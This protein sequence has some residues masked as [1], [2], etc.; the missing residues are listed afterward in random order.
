MEY[1]I[2]DK[3]DH[4]CGGGW[5]EHWN[6][7]HKLKGKIVPGTWMPEVKEKINRCS[8]GYHLASSVGF[9][10]YWY[11]D[12][13]HI[14]IAEHKPNTDRD[15][16]EEKIA[17][18]SVRLLSRVTFNSHKFLPEIL[19]R[20]RPTRTPKELRSVVDDL[21]DFDQPPTTTKLRT[22]AATL[23][24]YTTDTQNKLTYFTRYADVL[25]NYCN[26]LADESIWN[27]KDVLEAFRAYCCWWSDNR[28]LA[29]A[30]RESIDHAFEPAVD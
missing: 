7:P 25:Y 13:C 18:R 5:E 23:Y 27:L 9:V 12:T 16:D 24:D 19:S 28:L 3:F 20:T 6:L 10:T 11:W 26:F 17:Y 21:F 14:Y 2:L 4:S 8:N 29:C 30:Y 15:G 22:I 1:K